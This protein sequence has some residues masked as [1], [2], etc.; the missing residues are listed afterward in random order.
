MNEKKLSSASYELITPQIAAR[1]LG[2]SKNVNFRRLMPHVVNRYAMDMKSGLWADNGDPIQLNSLEQ[3]INGQHR[4]AAIVQSGCSI[5]MLVVRDAENLFDEGARR[6]LKQRLVANGEENCIVLASVVRLSKMYMDDRLRVSGGQNNVSN[7]M[8][9]GLLDSNPC[10]RDA[11]RYAAKFSIPP[12]S[13]CGMMYFAAVRNNHRDNMIRF[14]DSVHTGEGLKATDPAFHLRRRLLADKLKKSRL[15]R[16]EVIALCILAWNKWV[17]GIP[18]SN[19]AWHSVGP[20]AEDQPFP[21][22]SF[23]DANE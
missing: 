22:F 21:S 1:Y 9:L 17:N 8:A 10:L 12:Q 18:C 7:N 11:A 20:T 6:T 16:F 3:V 5:R 2:N 4:L 23:P 13:V 19:L 15:P 14:L